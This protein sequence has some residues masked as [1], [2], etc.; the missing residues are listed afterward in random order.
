[1]SFD[2]RLP[3]DS[4]NVSPTH[5]VR[6]ALVLVAGVAGAAAAVVVLLAVFIEALLPWV[7]TSLEARIFA[8]DWMAPEA[9]ALAAEDPRAAEVDALL[10][11]IERHWRENP[12]AFRVVVIEDA[13]PNAF[14]FPGGCVGV[15][16]GLLDAVTSENELAFVLAHEL[17]H[18]RNRDHLRG[19]GRGVAVALAM[20]ALGMS[21][22]SAATR[23]ATLSGDLASRAFDRSQESEAD[24]FAIGVV[25]AEYGHVGGALDFF[26]RLPREVGGADDRIV[27]YF[28][29]HPLTND[30]ANALRRR[31]EA[32]AYRGD[33]PL[34]PWPARAAAAAE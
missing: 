2:A 17:G 20:G 25:A 19:I 11:R 4:V 18:F 21:D 24:A 10:H 34:R 12:Y 6:E 8:N 13:S 1:M 14:A 3:D 28:A 9:I 7:P 29:T 16:T 30:R 15:T 26:S 23:I 33:G 32:Q 31:V 27:H 5:P 22:V